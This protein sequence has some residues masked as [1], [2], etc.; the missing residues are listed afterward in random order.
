VIELVNWS[1]RYGA[2][3]RKRYLA[4]AKDKKALYK[5]EVCGKDTVKR[6]STGIWKCKS[7]GAVFA[8]GAYTLRTEAGKVAER[9]I[10]QSQRSG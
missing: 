9:T 2:N 6:I 5:C 4:V 8:G 3:L 10:S 1:V 7:C